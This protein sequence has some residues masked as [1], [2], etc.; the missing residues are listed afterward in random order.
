MTQELF[1]KANFINH[2]ITVL[3]NIKCEKDQNHWIAFHTPAGDEDDFWSDEMQTDLKN[4]I[5]SELEKARKLFEE[6]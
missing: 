4:F 5:E 2:D 3:E 6:L 1:N